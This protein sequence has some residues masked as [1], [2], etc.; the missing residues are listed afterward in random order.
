MFE[1]QSLTYGELDARA[2]QLAHYLRALGV[3]PEMVVGLCVERSLEML[4]ALL[5][6]LKAGGAYLPLDP[7]YPP[8]RLGFMLADAQAPLVLTHSALADRLPAHDALVLHLDAELA[9][10]RRGAHDITG[11]RRPTAQ[12]RLCHLHLG[13]DGHAEGRQRHPWRHPQSGSG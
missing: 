11:Q 5:G 4:V 7:D 10:H 6:I 1:D 9:R 8:E 13:I 12:H 3:G 2:N